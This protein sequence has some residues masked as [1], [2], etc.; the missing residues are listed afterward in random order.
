MKKNKE[1]LKRNIYRYSMFMIYTLAGKIMNPRFI[2]A[3]NEII[4]SYTIIDYDKSNFYRY[5]PTTYVQK[6]ISISSKKDQYP[7]QDIDFK[8]DCYAMSKYLYIIYF[9]QEYFLFTDF[10]TDSYKNYIESLERIDE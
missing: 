4:L 2:K 6:N 1:T 10:W 5:L 8:D 3:K 7:E 9:T